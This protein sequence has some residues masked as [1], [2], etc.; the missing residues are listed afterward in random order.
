[1]AKGSFYKLFPSKDHLLMELLNTI[2]EN[3]GKVL[4]ILLNKQYSSPQEE[5][6]AF[7][8]I[9]FEDYRVNCITPLFFEGVFFRDKRISEKAEEISF[10]IDRLLKEF[11]LHLYG[12]ELKVYLWDLTLLLKGTLTQHMFLCR[13]PLTHGDIRQIAEMIG[14]MVDMAAKGLAEKR[15]QSV[16]SKK[17]LPPDSPFGKEQ[18]IN[19]IVGK[20]KA[21]VNKMKLEETVKEEYLKTLLLLE[22]TWA[23]RN[24]EIY[25]IKALL[26]YLQSIPEL[27][28]D[29]RELKELL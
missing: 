1:M 17:Y 18:K 4:R 21:S 6:K 29:C 11:L 23:Q 7:I 9:I 3:M 20:M 12:E 26:H 2:P 15:P 22:D 24:S 10:Q 5:L 14:L 28:K 27:E 16:L 25:L 8:S 13:Q 19:N